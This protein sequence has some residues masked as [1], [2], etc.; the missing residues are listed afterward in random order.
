MYWVK[1]ML[2]SA[3]VLFL[4]LALTGVVQ[5]LFLSGAAFALAYAIH[6]RTVAVWWVGCILLICGA[7]SSVW[8]L[9]VG[10][11]E[12]PIALD[13]VGLLVSIWMAVWWWKQRSYFSAK[14]RE[15]D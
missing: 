9:I 10:P 11:H 1:F 6:L 14:T 15:A 3:G 13:V 7:L 2:T 4:A 5:L 12:L 8:T